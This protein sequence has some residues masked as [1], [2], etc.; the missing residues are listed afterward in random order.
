MRRAAFPLVSVALALSAAGCH[1]TAPARP[2]APAVAA[3]PATPVSA[4]PPAPAEELKNTI[5]WSTAS[6]VNNFGYD[7]YRG[8]AENGPFTRI[9][10]SPI[11]GAGTTD[12]TQRYE[13]IDRDIRPGRDYFY[14]VESIST[15]GH[16]ERF[17]PVRKVPAKGAKP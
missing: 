6:E 11:L 16:R 14:Y 4:P 1:S 9:T 3:A 7:V 13:F 17:T 2:P 8:E 12:E 10:P 5:R 15:A